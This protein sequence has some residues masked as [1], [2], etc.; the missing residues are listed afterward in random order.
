M[1]ITTKAEDDRIAHV[2]PHAAH[3]A[4]RGE[5]AQSRAYHAGAELAVPEILDLPSIRA[6]REHARV[7]HGRGIVAGYRSA[8]TNM[9]WPMRWRR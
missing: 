4:V 7:E 8:N 6:C 5:H 2:H 9:I 3:G 1:V